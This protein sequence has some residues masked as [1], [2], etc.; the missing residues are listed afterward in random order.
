[1]DAYVIYADGGRGIIIVLL[2]RK[3]EMFFHD[4]VQ[5]YKYR[6]VHWDTLII[7]CFW[8]QNFYI[9]YI[10]LISL[11]ISFTKFKIFVKKGFDISIF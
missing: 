2:H 4:F 7:F 9:N 3:W 8:K 10:Y 1:M 6:T 11:E 5:I